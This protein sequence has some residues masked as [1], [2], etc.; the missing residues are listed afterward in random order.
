MV[1]VNIALFIEQDFVEY[2]NTEINLI[3]KGFWSLPCI[4]SKNQPKHPCIL[5]K[6]K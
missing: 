5:S 1:R 6:N 2:F 4:L 3:I